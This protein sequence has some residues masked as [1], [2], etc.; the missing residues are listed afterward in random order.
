MEHIVSSTFVWLLCGLSIILAINTLFFALVLKSDWEVVVI[1]FMFFL[2]GLGKYIQAAMVGPGFVRWYLSD[3]GFV[4]ITGWVF[5]YGHASSAKIRWAARTLAT[6]LVVVAVGL[7]WLVIKVQPQEIITI[8]TAR[9]DIVDVIIFIVS[10][11]FV[12]VLIDRLER[13]YDPV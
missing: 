11:S 1:M 8:P 12:M 3:V 13:K 7:E 4:G 2:Y 10:Y 9:G 5:L 6:I